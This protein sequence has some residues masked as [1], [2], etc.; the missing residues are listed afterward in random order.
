MQSNRLLYLFF[1]VHRCSSVFIRGFPSRPYG[2][3]TLMQDECRTLFEEKIRA[4]QGLA[5]PAQGGIESS[6]L[7]NGYRLLQLMAGNLGENLVEEKIDQDAGHG[8]V[9]PERPGPAGDFAM[10]IEALLESPA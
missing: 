6:L 9:H 8:D 4:R 1:S 7:R 2:F 3:R 10:K 5:P